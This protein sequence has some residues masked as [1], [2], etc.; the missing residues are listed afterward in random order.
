M[1]PASVQRLTNN[2][3]FMQHRIVY[4]CPNSDTP[5]GGV[6]VIYKHAA[7]LNTLGTPA[8]VWHPGD[9]DFKCSWF[10]HSTPTLGDK[11][12][13]PS[14]DL[15]VLPEI[16][17]SSH[18]EIFKTLGYKV[19]IYVQ[20]AYMTH[21]N[22]SQDRPDAILKAYRDAD[23]ILSISQDTSAYIHEV[24]GV[25]YEKIILQRYSIDHQIFKPREKDKIITY[26]PRKMGQHSARV[27]TALSSLLPE[28]WKIQSIDKMTENQVAAIL[29]SSIIFLAFSEFEGLPVPPVE[30]ALSG[31]IV[32]GYH[33]QGGK[34]YWNSPNFINIDQGDIRSFISNTISTIGMIEQGNIPID[35]L[36]QGIMKI[37]KDFSHEHE[38]DLLDVFNKYTSEIIFKKKHDL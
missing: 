33:G 22:L 25:G 6:K 27:V 35:A 38:L 31:N 18:V 23:I 29:S 21:V 13:S 30:A 20:N 11:D 37:A 26:M 28:G 34:E 17:A 9:T 32:I 14:T 5:S 12:L 10:D 4:G 36:N 1:T 7:M 16:W 19:G 8:F 24:L 2:G 15:I 3:Q